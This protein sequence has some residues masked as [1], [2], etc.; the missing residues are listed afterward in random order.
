M[1]VG[2]WREGESTIQ[3][4]QMKKWDVLNRALPTLF[5][6]VRARELEEPVVPSV[7]AGTSIVVSLRC[8]GL[9][10]GL[11]FSYLDRQRQVGGGVI[12]IILILL[13]WLDLSFQRLA[14]PLE[15]VTEIYRQLHFTA[16]PVV[17]VVVVGAFSLQARKNFLQKK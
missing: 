8:H 16:F 4:M 3:P 13:C 14:P 7:Q 10:F 12:H 1:G 9:I 2:G 11:Q 6:G 17:V 15:T 5:T